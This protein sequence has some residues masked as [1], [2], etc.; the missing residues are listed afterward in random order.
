VA[1]PFLDQIEK[2]DT[3]VIL[4]KIELIITPVIIKA[5]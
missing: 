5:E 1:V 4:E 2:L 3:Q